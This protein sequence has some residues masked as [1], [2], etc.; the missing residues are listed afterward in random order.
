MT[1]R[2]PS[3]AAA[4]A[5][6]LADVDT[7]FDLRAECTRLLFQGA[8][9]PAC[10][11]LVIGVLCVLL[12]RHHA[13][14]LELGVWWLSVTALA[15]MRLHQARVVRRTP[16]A[17]LAAPRWKTFFTFGSIAAALSLA[18]AILRLVPPD[19]FS[20][21]V[22]SYGLIGSVV[23]IASIAYAVNLRAFFF[24]A[25]PCLLPA[26]L[27]LVTSPY[28]LQHGWGELTLVLLGTLSIVAWQI[29]R[30]IGSN[31]VQRQQNAGLIQV[32]QRARADA[33]G[34]NTELACEVQQRRRA[35][36]ELRDAYEGLEQ[37]VVERTAE[38]AR[39]A[40]DL[41]QS[42][43][44]LNLALEASGLGLWDWNLA[45][46]SVH[47]S[48]M[49][50]RF[51]VGEPENSHPLRPEVH[52]DDLLPVRQA[53]ID[54]LKGR[55]DVYVA[56]YRAR[57][58]D[59][60][61][62]WIEDRGRA[63][64]RDEQGRVRRMIG[65][66]RDITATRQ[67]IEQQRLAATVFE[68]A[69]E[70]IV[71]LDDQYRVLAI[72]EAC[73]TLSGFTRDE[74]LGRRV[75]R[76][77]ASEATRARYG[78]MREMLE[79]DGSWQGEQL[80]LRKNGETYPQWLQMR[81]VHDEAGRIANIVGFLTDLTI[82]RQV[83]ERLRYLTHYDELTGLAN[84]SLLKERLDEAC[85]RVRRSGRNLAVLHLDL[86]RFKTLNESLGHEIA[87]ELLKEIAR[88][89]SQVLPDADTLARLSGDEF[90]VLLEAYGSLSGLVHLGTRLLKRIRQP[91][92]VDGHELVV[93]ASIGATLM[94]DNAREAIVLLRQ[95][96]TAMQHAK[97]LGGN[98]LQFFTDR[99]QLASVETLQLENQLRKALDEDQLEVFYQPRMRLADD[100][101]DA[102]EALVRWRHPHQGL[103]A[104]GHFIPL[105][106]E[107]GLIIPLGETVLRKACAQARRWQQDGTG[108]IR[109]SVNLSA[110][111]LRQGNLVTLVRQVL[112]DTGLPARLL[113]LELTESQ[114]LDD[115]ENAIT[116]CRQLRELGVSLAIDDF[117]TGYSSLSY[118]KRFP[119]DYVKIDRAFVAELDQCG[120]DAAIVRAIIAMAH[121]LELKVVAEGV[122]TEPQRDFLR[123]Q[124]CDEI[125]GYLLSPPVEA[126]RFV[127]LLR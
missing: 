67:Q 43:T 56:E 60:P 126:V 33:E 39:A 82:R 103:I 62:L 122:E 90:V 77:F 95:A 86:D 87:D 10:L 12:L 51:G 57:T 94:P 115:V 89:I 111:Q 24:F 20:V 15:L 3:I 9:V 102:A 112:D 38:L 11:M 96:D 37:R 120:E 19:D 127:Q 41:S 61:W 107:T 49:A 25:V 110:K 53:L 8:Q 35:E 27:G 69:S 13:A 121:S 17:E 71:I 108:E 55:T 21:Q 7:G 31:L 1:S 68:A 83:E 84:R 73:C 26:G 5:S 105:A 47:H 72:N 63:I 36:Q 58:P 124:G 78:E 54:H 40:C 75:T 22:M 118:L 65:T 109:V 81:V 88:R 100:Y 70:G 50:I 29:N 106:E 104:P 16:D 116:T 4:Q 64:E 97:H 48:R 66:R 85:Q 92:I 30:L 123:A 93:S 79:R 44:R 46:G 99:L 45:E 14:P 113:E 101:I 6:S 80:E 2:S 23:L 18:Y 117:G 119:V 34:L 42:E 74:L 52:P 32:L 59:G 28:P 91:V 114:L 76:L 98:T 125:Q